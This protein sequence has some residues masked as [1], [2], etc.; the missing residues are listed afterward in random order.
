[1][2]KTRFRQLPWWQTEWKRLLL[3][4]DHKSQYSVVKTTS[5]PHSEFSMFISSLSHV[6]NYYVRWQK[7]EIWKSNA[8]T[9]TYFWGFW[10]ITKNGSFLTLSQRWHDI[11][12]NLADFFFIWYFYKWNLSKAT[13]I[14]E[15]I[16]SVWTFNLDIVLKLMT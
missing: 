11:F 6:R 1:M 2:G 14:W 13:K 7:R 12:I 16:R 10:L 9:S 8:R 3:V 4:L 5:Y 15:S